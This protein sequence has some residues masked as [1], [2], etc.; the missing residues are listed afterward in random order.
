MLAPAL[1]TC[2]FW[3]PVHPYDQKILVNGA[4]KMSIQTLTVDGFKN[5]I[6]ADNGV[7]EIRF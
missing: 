3:S 2:V 7:Q 6:L 5:D 4:L 1:F